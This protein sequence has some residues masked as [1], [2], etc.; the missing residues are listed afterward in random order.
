MGASLVQ[1]TED[2]ISEPA[3]RVCLASHRAAET[4][5]GEKSTH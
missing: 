2:T 4:V 1:N 3:E 5:T